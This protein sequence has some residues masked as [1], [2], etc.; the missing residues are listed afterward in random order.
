[1]RLV[2]SPSFVVLQQWW[3]PIS[4]EPD[5]WKTWE[6]GEWRDIPIAE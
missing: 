5:D 6:A 4:D 2:A 3:V 1:M